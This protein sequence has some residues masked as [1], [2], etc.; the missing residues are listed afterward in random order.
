VSDAG[1]ERDY[2]FIV[3]KVILPASACS[4]DPCILLH[5]AAQMFGFDIADLR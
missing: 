2:G 4:G 1:A 3:N 5:Q